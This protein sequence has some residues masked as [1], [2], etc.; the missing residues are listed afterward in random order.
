MSKKSYIT[1]EGYSFKDVKQSLEDWINLY[2]GKIETIFTLEVLEKNKKNYCVNVNGEIDNHTFN[3]LVNYLVYHKNLASKAVVRGYTS[4]SNKNIF[5]LEELDKRVV[6]FIPK[7]DKEYD[8]VYAST[9]NGKTFI[10][11]FGGKTKEIDFLITFEEP[12]LSE[13][14]KTEYSI[15]PKAKKA[16]TV[17]SQTINKDN[18]KQIALFFTP[19]LLVN[20]LIIQYHVYL[21][22]SF[23]I[24]ACL[25]FTWIFFIHNSFLK[26]QNSFL[27]LFGLSSV[28]ALVGVSYDKT[29]SV[30][31][32]SIITSPLLL[33]FSFLACHR[34]LR[35]VYLKI[36]KTEPKFL[37]DDFGNYEERTWS[38]VFYTMI[39]ML[40]PIAIS[41]YTNT[42]LLNYI[43]K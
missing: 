33:P 25:L 18:T 17:S 28:F 42:H 7:E 35:F 43:Y 36:L 38:N 31:F 32:G 23:I 30:D 8:N 27:I 13:Y 40:V 37:T 34:L 9:G 14:I 6:I 29:L 3:F 12:D 10:V 26:N 39:M 19:L 24:L 21:K 22:L 5:S 15:K 20:I 1:I 16:N 2:A 4:A 11:D 41:I